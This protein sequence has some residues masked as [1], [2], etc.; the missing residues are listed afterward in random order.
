VHE[1]VGQTTYKL[2]LSDG[3]NLDPTLHVSKFREHVGPVAA[4]AVQHLHS[5]D[6][7]IY[8]I[9]ENIEID[10]ETVLNRKLIPRK[11]GDVGV[12]TVRWLINLLNDSTTWV[13][14]GL[15]LHPKSIL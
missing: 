7:M 13:L 6:I 8:M 12:P 4:P 9:M 3:Y 10:P 2:L 5:F 14:G 11:Q 15:Q 1:K